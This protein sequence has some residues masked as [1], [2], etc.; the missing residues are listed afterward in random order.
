MRQPPVVG[1]IAVGILLGP[2][3]LGELSRGLEERLFPTAVMPDLRL[4]ARVALVLFLV[5]VGHELG[6]RSVRPGGRAVAG[7]VVGAFGLPMALGV[8]AGVVLHGMVEPGCAALPFA[9]Y[10]G[11][12]LSITALPVLAGILADRGLST[13][14]AG[15][16]ALTAATVMD[17][18]G[19]AV[20]TLSLVLA[21]HSD[22]AG[23]ADLAAE[24]GGYLAAAWLVRRLLRRPSCRR[25]L[26]GGAGPALT[27]ALAFTS[28]GIAVRLGLHAEFGALLAGAVLPRPTADPD[29]AGPSSVTSLAGTGRLLLPVFFVVSGIAIDLRSLSGGGL[30]FLAVLL[31]LAVGGK[32]LGGYLGARVGGLR[33]HDSLT[34][35]ILMN[36]RGLT[37]LIV[38]SIGLTAGLLDQELYTALVLMALVTTVMTGPL[39]SRRAG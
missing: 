26:S 5:G 24:V 6:R 29:A 30:R 2:S 34:V 20:L 35:G 1:E 39:I 32:V 36:T 28:A 16:V 19:W 21:R 15:A 22:G 37:E 8:T 14:T 13:S 38:L 7:V 3:V 18:L 17:A 11:V 9:L 10:T 27:A 33:P 12:A 25:R 23:L 4:L 31:P